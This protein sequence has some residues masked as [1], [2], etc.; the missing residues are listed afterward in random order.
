MPIIGDV[1]DNGKS[2][3]AEGAVDERIMISEVLR[4]RKLSKTLITGC[5][6]RGNEDK[7]LLGLLTF[8]N[9]ESGRTQRLEI[10]YVDGFNAS[11]RRGKLRDILNETFKISIFALGIDQDSLCIVKNP[12]PNEVRLGEMINKGPEADSLN[13]SGDLNFSPFHSQ[14]N[15]LLERL[16]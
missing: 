13:D 15:F 6:V 7:F 12:S 3:S 1:L 11:K 5:H 16:R 9:F 10:G 4:G 8:F 14:S 2:R